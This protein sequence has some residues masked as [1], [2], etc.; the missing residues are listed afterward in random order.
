M[1]HYNPKRKPQDVHGSRRL[2]EPPL[3]PGINIQCSGR[4]KHLNIA[5]AATKCRRA[6][7]FLHFLVV[8]FSR[9]YLQILQSAALFWS[10]LYRLEL[11]RKCWR[12]RWR[13]EMRYCPMFGC[14][15]TIR[16]FL[17]LSSACQRQYICRCCFLSR[18]CIVVFFCHFIV[19]AHH[20]LSP[21]RLFFSS[22]P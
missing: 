20:V 9:T 10:N 22:N 2:W 19:E 12:T 14:L 17:F 13:W 6:T 1:Q 5:V 7:V 18:M 16:A 8:F 11:C 21:T 15:S 3:L 4:E